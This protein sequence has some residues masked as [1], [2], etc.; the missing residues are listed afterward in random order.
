MNPRKALA[1]WLDERAAA[2]AAQK[3]VPVPAPL[4]P[5][6]DTP[7]EE[8]MIAGAEAEEMD[9]NPAPMEPQSEPA[10]LISELPEPAEVPA[11]VPAITCS[12]ETVDEPRE[13]IRNILRRALDRRSAFESPLQM[14]DPAEEHCEEEA[15]E[16]ATPAEEIPPIAAWREAA[17]LPVEIDADII[18]MLEHNP[19]AVSRSYADLWNAMSAPALAGKPKA[20]AAAAAQPRFELIQGAGAGASAADVSLPPGMH[21][22]SVLSRAIAS[23]K[24]FTGVV[25]SVGVTDNDGRPCSDNDLLRSIEI[26]IG[27]LLADTEFACRRG[28]DEFVIVCPDPRGAEAHMRLT[29]ISEQLWDYQLRNAHRFSLVFAWGSA[30]ARH[31]SLAVAVAEASA[32]MVETR[33]TRRVVSV[34]LLRSQHRLAAM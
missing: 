31:E 15:A 32:R 33:R 27:S 23:G 13:E 12:E 2:R 16:A 34:D 29:A 28:N 9:A 4:P 1:E 26:F 22:T 24:R 7:V 17:P 20:Q 14:E 3:R 25:L 21:E 6:Y 30:E 5:Q 19:P 10:V 18:E 8:E 11:A